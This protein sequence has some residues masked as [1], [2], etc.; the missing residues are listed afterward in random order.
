M[1]ENL[2]RKLIFQKIEELGYSSCKIYAERTIT[3]LVEIQDK[4][5]KSYSQESGGLSLELGK[6]G[7]GP[8]IH[9]RTNQFSTGALLKLLG[10]NDAMIEPREP[11]ARA[12]QS[13]VL[14]KKLQNLQL[15]IRKINLDNTLSSPVRFRYQDQ[16][17][18]FEL[19]THPDRIEQ[20][21]SSLGE[22]KVDV[23]SALRG[24][25]L[26]FCYEMSSGDLADFERKLQCIPEEIRRRIE[27]G[28]TERWPLPEGEI[29]VGWSSKA[30]AKLTDCF[31]RGFEGDLVLKNFSFLAGTSLPLNFKFSLQEHPATKSSTIDHE[32]EPR[33]PVLIFDGQKPR[34]LA[35]D[36][37]IANEFAVDSTGH[38]RRASFDSSSS[39][40]FWH[41]ILKGHSETD[42]I[43]ELMSEGI[44]VEDLEIQ[45]LD[46]I[47]GHVTLHLSQAHLVHQNQIGESIEPSNWTLCLSDLMGSLSYFSKNASTLGLFHT[48]QKQRILTEYTTPDA[49][50]PSL[51]LPGSVP[52]NHYW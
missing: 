27:M 14:A 42:S 24:K 32:G 44:W 1:L 6:K 5:Q 51:R 48:K 17:Q 39:I 19:C 18:V 16:R 40:G 46:L 10:C 23:V 2:D 47:S 50:S 13:L 8:V 7:N 31:V 34:S 37:F 4:D 35:T 20:G 33:K 21:E 38:S 30:L 49:L 45:E 25:T 12:S 3:T 28:S 29:S 9:L 22:V 43:L 41:P 36:L 15:L 26:A 11:S 52:K